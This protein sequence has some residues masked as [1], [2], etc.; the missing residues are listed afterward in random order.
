[1]DLDL[2]DPGATE[3][4][5]DLLRMDGDTTIEQEKEGDESGMSVG[6][7]GMCA[8]GAAEVL[9]ELRKH[10]EWIDKKNEV[11][12]EEVHI[13]SFFYQYW[14]REQVSVT[15]VELGNRWWQCGKE[16]QN[17]TSFFYSRNT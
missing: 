8:D 1:M 16:V 14:W 17:T 6:G 13:H 9:E 10:Y 3:R 11:G 15:R 4:V 5:D 2:G 12:K 7:E